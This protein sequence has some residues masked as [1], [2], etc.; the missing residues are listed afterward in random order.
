M[1]ALTLGWTGLSEINDEGMSGANGAEIE[2]GVCTGLATAGSIAWTVGGIECKAGEWR[3]KHA[4][5]YTL[6]MGKGSM[7]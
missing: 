2:R 3:T 5:S 1:I 4:A 6:E 7:A